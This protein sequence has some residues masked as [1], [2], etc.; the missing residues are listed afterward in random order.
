MSITLKV[1]AP[2][3]GN[4]AGAPVTHTYTDVELLADRPAFE[5]EYEHGEVRQPNAELSLPVLLGAADY[6]GLPEGDWRAQVL[7][8][9]AEVL[10][11]RMRRRE[12]EFDSASSK[13]VVRV[14]DDSTHRAKQE[15]KAT[16]LNALPEAVYQAL[17]YVLR[18]GLVPYEFKP[19]TTRG[20]QALSYMKELAGLRM[21]KLVDVLAAV[22]DAAELDGAPAELWDYELTIE[23]NGE[24]TVASRDATPRIYLYSMG[25]FNGEVLDQTAR[26]FL[27]ATEY[28]RTSL[29]LPDWDGWQLVENVARLCAWTFSASYEAFPSEQITVEFIPDVLTEPE[30]LV[31]IDGLWDRAGYTLRREDAWLP[32]MALRYAE[33]PEQPEIITWGTGHAHVSADS[34]EIDAFYPA[35]PFARAAAERWAF[36]ERGHVGDE[37]V[38]LDFTMAVAGRYGDEGWRVQNVSQ[39]SGATGAT[40]DETRFMGYAALT[41]TDD[42]RAYLATL[43]LTA[44][45]SEHRVVVLFR[46][47]TNGGTGQLAYTCEHWARQ[48]FKRYQR[49]RAERDVVEGAIIGDEV[50]FSAFR[51]GYA[52]GG[53]SFLGAPWFIERVERQTALGTLALR[54]GRVVAVPQAESAQPYYTGPV[55]ALEGENIDVENNISPEKEYHIIRWDWPTM[56]QGRAVYFDVEAYDFGSSAWQALLTSTYGLRAFDFSW[57]QADDENGDRYSLYRVRAVML[58]ADASETN[59]PWSEVRIYF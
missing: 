2:P 1:Y 39:A 9:G 57:S 8:N 32:D 51:P 55:T 37:E 5:S 11:G 46:R 28:S 10:N 20:N 15:L 34:A 12:V 27:D 59:G 6:F 36:G 23:H 52:S 38:E 53:C 56:G 7:Y 4:P 17:P 26:L 48:L 25:G 14:V 24:D 44:S 49:S 16:R 58:E 40:W 3:V 43:E 21:Y 45:V 33:N 47:I 42:E 18:S 13:F 29:T 41:G 31:P 54:A 35:P 30:A 19:N 50:G 22:F